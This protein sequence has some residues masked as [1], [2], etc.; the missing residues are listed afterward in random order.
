MN[1]QNGLRIVTASAESIA[2][3][4]EILRSGGLVA[5]PT[6]TVYGL[7]ADSG[8]DRAVAATFAAKERPRFNPL[9]VH[10]GNLEHAQSLALFSPGALAL[11]EAF[12]PGP[13]TLVLPRRT[14]AP[15]SLLAS[16]GLDT[17][18]LRVPAHETAQRVL[19][20]SGLAISAPSANRSGEVSPTT[21][22]H[23]AESLG[24]RVD[25]I[26]D[27]GPA[28]WGIESSIVGFDARGP[29]LLR[30]GAL[31]REKIEAVAGTLHSPQSGSVTS[32]GQLRSHYAPQT[33]L[34]LG[35]EGLRADEALLAF[36]TNV[37]AH[38]GATRNLSPLGDLY[39]AAANLFSMLRELDSAGCVGIAV[40]PVPRH[41]LGEAINDRLHRAA[42]P[43][44]G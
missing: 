24:D 25:L 44:E 20:E 1:A 35:V 37:P 14:G 23:V 30:S 16:A 28:Q 6:E 4:A 42:A 26:L 11:A 5:I 8:N 40:M 9:I 7:G 10:I 2:H 38:T 3:A 19:R 21:A 27:A 18:A 39:E 22:T 36:G 12:W 33:P 32:P 34:R 15:V 13:L 17:I 29:L 31:S 41:G 43:R